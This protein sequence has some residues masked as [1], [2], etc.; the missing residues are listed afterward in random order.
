MEVLGRLMW[1]RAV[2]GG[3]AHRQVGRSGRSGR[4][5]GSLADG[6]GEVSG[7]V[8][9]KLAVHDH[10]VNRLLQVA[11]EHLCVSLECVDFTWS[12]ERT[13]TASVQ[14]NDRANADVDYAEKALVLLLELLLIKDLHRQNALFVY[15]PVDAVSRGTT[16]ADVWWCGVHVEA[17]IP[18]GVQRLLDHTR[19]ARLL[20]IDRGHGEGVREA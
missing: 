20:A 5:G 18:V 19:S 14:V 6:R 1:C 15:P 3:T 17:L 7:E 2:H 8:E 9:N 4:I 16:F 12:M 13:V 10:V 11:C